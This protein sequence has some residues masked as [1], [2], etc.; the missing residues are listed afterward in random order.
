MA[1]PAAAHRPVR[2]QKGRLT[3]WNFRT[4][5]VRA[6]PQSTTPFTPFASCA[7]VHIKLH[8]RME[9]PEGPAR[10]LGPVQRPLTSL[11]LV[12]RKRVPSHYTAFHSGVGKI[13]PLAP[14][15]V[16]VRRVAISL[17]GPGQSPV[18][19]ACCVGSLR[20]VG[21]CGRKIGPRAPPPH[22]ALLCSFLRFLLSP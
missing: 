11:C 9:A 1:P 12:C 16:T 21:R 7:H 14:P 22:G 8:F 3:I 20:S 6:V 15:C 4:S 2:Q 18:P 19:F 10:P 5:L 13:G 17:R